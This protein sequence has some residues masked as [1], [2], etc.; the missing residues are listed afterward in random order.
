MAVRT[1]DVTRCRT[2]VAA[3]RRGTLARDPVQISETVLDPVIHLVRHSRSARCG[4]ESTPAATAK[5]TERARVRAHRYGRTYR[6]TERNSGAE[7]RFCDHQMPSRWSRCRRLLHRSLRRTSRLCSHLSHRSINRSSIL[8]IA[9]T[10]LGV[11][12][13]A[14]KSPCTARSR[15]RSHAGSVRAASAPAFPAR[16]RASRGVVHRSG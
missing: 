15:P 11:R 9:I 13:R 14:G 16:T 1:T 12:C 3:P 10:M 6:N 7:Q 2:W 4:R 5:D 8:S